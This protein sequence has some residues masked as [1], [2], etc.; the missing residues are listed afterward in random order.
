LRLLA[1]LLFLSA[2]SHGVC[3][4][5]STLAARGPVAK[6][7]RPGVQ[8]GDTLTIASPV[9]FSGAHTLPFL[10]TELWLD[11]VKVHIWKTGTDDE[12]SLNLS[13]GRHVVAYHIVWSSQT[14]EVSKVVVP[15]T[16]K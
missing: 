12:L 4:V 16:V 2:L 15:V 11:G 6:V 9:Q 5:N 3:S 1:A 10:R 7:C 14:G 13:S 8:V